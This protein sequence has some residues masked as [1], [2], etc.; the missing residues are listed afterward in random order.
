MRGTCHFTAVWEFHVNSEKTRAFEKAYGPEGNW[1]RLFR[2]GEGYIRTELIRD[3]KTQGCYLTLDFWA[4]RQAYQRFKKRNLASYKSLDKKCDSL[5]E[6]ER[7]IGEFD[8]SVSRSLI[9][10]RAR[11]QVK[12]SSSIRHVRPATPADIQHI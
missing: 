7:L 9:Q 12:S 8:K 6:S 11:E 10:A 3:H 2:R 5:T 1:A 4:S